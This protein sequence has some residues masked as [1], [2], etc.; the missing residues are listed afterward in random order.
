MTLLELA[1]LLLIAA[2]GMLL[3]TQ[4]M[5]RLTRRRRG[6]VE[7]GNTSLPV[8]SVLLVGLGCS[9][10]YLLWVAHRGAPPGALLDTS[11]LPYI[12]WAVVAFGVYL[13]LFILQRRNAG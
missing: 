6:P 12:G 4:R 7:V 1:P 3:F 13:L 8:L 11:W 9:V 2:A 10:F 5:S